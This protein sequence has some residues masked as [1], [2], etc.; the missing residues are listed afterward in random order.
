MDFTVTFTRLP[1]RMSQCAT[2][3]LHRDIVRLLRT[4]PRQAKL[5]G[6]APSPIKPQQ[7]A[8]QALLK[9]GREP[10]GSCEAPLQE[11]GK[12]PLPGSGEAWSAAAAAPASCDSLDDDEWEDMQ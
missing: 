3:G 9:E 4:G 1:S 6:S 7:L 12:Q 11:G 2:Q 5:R 8:A 10:P